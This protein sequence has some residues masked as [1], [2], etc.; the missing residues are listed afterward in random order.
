M[1]N[2]QNLTDDEILHLAEDREHLTEDARLV[3]DG[4]LQRRGLSPSD[5]DSYRAD[6]VAAED[7]EKLKRLTINALLCSPSRAWHETPWQGNRRRDSSGDFEHYEATLWFVAFWFPIFPIA[8]FT[9]RR[10]LERWW[11]G[12]AA[13]EEIPIERHPRNWEQILG[14]WS[15]ALVVVWAICLALRLLAHHPEWLR[16]M[17]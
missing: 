10:D 5:I 8:T 1:A 6:R 3:L 2:Y 11:G 17:P 12:I 7:A 16:H 15:K 9:V 13:S 14:T 4:E